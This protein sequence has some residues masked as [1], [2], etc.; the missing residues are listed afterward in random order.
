MPEYYRCYRHFVP[1]PA[2]SVAA[3]AKWSW[4]FCRN[5][6]GISVNCNSTLHTYCQCFAGPL[7]TQTC[8]MASSSVGAG[9]PSTACFQCKSQKVSTCSIMLAMTLDWP[10]D[11]GKI[12]PLLGRRA[13]LPAMR[14][15]EQCMSISE[16]HPPN[17]TAPRA[18]SLVAGS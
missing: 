8:W 17:P 10:D 2:P 3:P 16:Q 13:T 6:P 11:F 15:H 14:S 18:W 5:I 12:G 1:P 9:R 4:G 7:P